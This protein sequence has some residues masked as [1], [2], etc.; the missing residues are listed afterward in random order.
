MKP[1]ILLP[2]CNE[3][4][5]LPAVL[6]ELLPLAERHGCTV[7]VGLNDCTDDSVEVMRAYPQVITGY[8]MQRGYGHGCLAAMQA[9][10][11]A[12]VD[13]DC[14]IFMAADGASDP[15]L[16]P[17]LLSFH[18]R[19]A[20]LVLG[21]RTLCFA[22][23]RGLGAV[24]VL[25][26][27]VLGAWASLL[28]GYLYSDLGPQRLIS[29]RLMQCW[30][31]LGPDTHWGWTIEPQII[32]PM[33]SMNVETLCTIER[34][35]VAGEQKVTGVSWRQSLRIGKLIMQKGWRMASAVKQA[36]HAIPVLT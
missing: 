15:A 31:Q 11:D 4:A 7:A 20:D 5:C 18:Q 10:S 27:L 28:S 6:A 12:G 36:M 21:Q 17:E 35:R 13:A 23:L 30:Q 14:F 1:V 33:L 8:S 25:S 34:P 22:S 26:N 32:A 3:A 19:G 2:A 16:L 9:V 24:R 29:A